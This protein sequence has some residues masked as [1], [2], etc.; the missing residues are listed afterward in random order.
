[1]PRSLIQKING[2]KTAT[3]PKAIYRFNAISIK[4]PMAFFTEL[5]QKVVQF[6]WKHTHTHK[7]QMIKAILRKVNRP[8]GIKLSDFRL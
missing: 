4:L 5:Q 2:V 3:L 6:V 7:I 8:G 1:M